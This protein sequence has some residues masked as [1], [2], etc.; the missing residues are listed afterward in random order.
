L[1][2]K[3][4]FPDNNNCNLCFGVI[5]TV[6]GSDAASPADDDRRDHTLHNRLKKDMQHL[7]GNIER[8]ELHQEVQSAVSLLVDGFTAS[9]LQSVFQMNTEVFILLHHLHL[10]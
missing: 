1:K 3:M 10:F 4:Q 6:P 9:P 5:T 2:I 7:A 8:P